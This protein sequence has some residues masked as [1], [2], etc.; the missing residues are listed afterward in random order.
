MIK[1]T[2]NN[3]NIPGHSTLLNLLFDVQPTTV[4][5]VLEGL[6]DRGE[7]WGREEV[8]LYG[9]QLGAGL[10]YLHERGIAHRDIKPRN[11]LVS[12]EAQVLQVCDLGSACRLGGGAPL[13]AYICSRSSAAEKYLKRT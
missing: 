8:A 4:H 3:L 11:L 2:N 10:A 5:E 13:T 9:A 6:A 1:Q 7:A 12:L